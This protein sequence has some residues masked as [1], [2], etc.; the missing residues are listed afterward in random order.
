MTNFLRA[1]PFTLRMEGGYSDHPSDP[2]GA[3]QKGITQAVYDAYRREHSQSVAPVR[4]ISDDEVEAIY[5]SRYWT[6]CKAE[7]LP[8]PAS[9]CHFDAAVNHGVGG[10]AR[11]LQRAV[12]VVADGKIGPQTLAAA[13]HMPLAL[14]VGR[15]LWER[16]GYYERIMLGNASLRVF[17]LGWLA[18][19]N[20]L[21]SRCRQEAPEIA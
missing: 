10:A 8:W 12:G 21:R 18:R 5:F 3:T 19:V 16:L 15:M 9:L 20:A 17:A 7:A 11:I 4:G 2:G 6:V 1:L 13:A 14:L